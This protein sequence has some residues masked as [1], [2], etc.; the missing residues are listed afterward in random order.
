MDAGKR[1]VSIMPAVRQERINF[2]GRGNAELDKDA[3]KE[4][5]NMVEV[6]S[7]VFNSEG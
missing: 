7:K 2:R 4:K 3:F 5:D 6:I 1:S